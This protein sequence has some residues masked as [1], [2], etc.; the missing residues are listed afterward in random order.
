MPHLRAKA[1]PPPGFGIPKPSTDASAEMNMNPFTMLHSGPTEIDISRSEQRY[2]HSSTADAENRFL[3]SLMSSSTSNAPPE[4]F[5]HSEGMPGYIGN[6]AGP[7]P[8]GEM[9]LPL[10]QHRMCF[11]ILVPHSKLSLV[12]DN[13]RQ[14]P[15]NQNVPQLPWPRTSSAIAEAEDLL[16]NGRG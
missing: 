3:E 5:V 4:K 14:Q 6:T 16:G 12:A 2:N 11:M 8:S 13:A 7:M 1:R 15:H 9:L 10:F